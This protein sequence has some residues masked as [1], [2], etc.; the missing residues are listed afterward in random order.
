MLLV[1]STSM[2]LLLTGTKSSYAQEQP[3]DL[4][5]L[6]NLDLFDSRS[7]QNDP[8]QPESGQPASMLDQIR[9]LDAMGYL[10]SANQNSLPPSRPLPDSA[11]DGDRS[12]A[13]GT[14]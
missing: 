9:T 14:P 10:G 3:P 13:P 6:L 12:G 11:P 5:M 7:S 4:Q 8:G 2:A 1:I